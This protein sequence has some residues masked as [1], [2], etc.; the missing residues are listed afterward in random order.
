VPVDR[1]QQR[2]EDRRSHP[3]A[4]SKRFDKEHPLKIEE[5]SPYWNQGIALGQKTI[6]QEYR[7]I[8]NQELHQL[9][10]HP[11][12]SEA[13]IDEWRSFLSSD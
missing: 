10:E 9:E 6:P 13:A 4:H 12:K 11:D 8:D 5:I 7:I 3:G 1:G 2:L